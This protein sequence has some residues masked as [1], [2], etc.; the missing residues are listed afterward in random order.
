MVCVSGNL[1]YHSKQ[2]VTRAMS[3]QSHALF[4]KTEKEIAAVHSFAEDF[5]FES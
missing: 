1:H 2:N 3:S 4:E 5:V